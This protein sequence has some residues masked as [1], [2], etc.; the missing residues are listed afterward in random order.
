MKYA[1]MVEGVLHDYFARSVDTEGRTGR[2]L[3]EQDRRP[4]IDHS[5]NCHVGLRLGSYCSRTF[6]KEKKLRDKVFEIGMASTLTVAYALSIYLLHNIEI[7][8]PD[9]YARWQENLCQ[10]THGIL[11]TDF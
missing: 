2:T 6:Q 7:I 8:D 10:V 5:H 11:A 9:D 1:F 4:C 3:S